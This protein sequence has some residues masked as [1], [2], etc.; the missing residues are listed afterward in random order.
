MNGKLGVLQENY[1]EGDDKQHS[2]LPNYG[3]KTP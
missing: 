2:K 1:D 3:I